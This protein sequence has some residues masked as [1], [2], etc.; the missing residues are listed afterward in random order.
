MH[1]R[2]FLLGLGA[3]LVAAPA[4]VRATSL[5]PVRGIVMPVELPDFVP[6]GDGVFDIVYGTKNIFPVQSFGPIRDGDVLEMVFDGEKR[7]FRVTNAHPEPITAA[8]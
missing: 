1:R 4:V 7:V 8:G 6:L 5:M 2:S 3:S